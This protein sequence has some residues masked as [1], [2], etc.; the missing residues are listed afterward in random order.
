M[1]TPRIKRIFVGTIQHGADLYESLSNIAV[2]EDI[3]LGQI[4]G[5]GATTHAVV[6]YYD[7][8]QRQYTSMVFPGGMEIL[9]LQ[10]NIS[11]RDGKPFVHAH[12][13][14]GGPQ[15]QTVGG[16]L[17][18][19]TRVFACEVIVHELEGAQLT[20]EY[21]PATGLHLWKHSSLL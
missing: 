15:G 9:S 13:I 4:S 16:H 7:Q 18:S 12:I 2:A 11:L 3:T 8:H 1:T 17:L 10:G 19:G 6:A 5:I 20:R 14:L 21:D